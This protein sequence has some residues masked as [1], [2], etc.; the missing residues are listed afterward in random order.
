MEKR[1]SGWL[2]RKGGC[3]VVV[4]QRVKEV[5]NG[6]STNKDNT[7]ILKRHKVP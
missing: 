3:P 1:V 5:K 4:R 7:L 2:R 6:G